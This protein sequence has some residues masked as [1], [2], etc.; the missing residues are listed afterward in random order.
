VKAVAAGIAVII[1]LIGTSALAADMAV[2]VPPP[3]VATD[4]G[5]YFWIDGMADRVRLPAYQLGL[6]NVSVGFPTDLDPVQQFV[7][8]LDGGGVRGA[9]GYVMPATSVK[10]EFGGSY[11]AAK[12]SQSQLTSNSNDS[13]TALF[14]NGGGQNHAFNCDTTPHVRRRV[15]S[16]LITLRGSSMERCPTPGNMIG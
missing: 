10:F 9:I 12:E 15:A 3:V 6:H 4:G 14:L 1:T 7:P 13:V 16:A 5:Y 2:K 11:A 8:S